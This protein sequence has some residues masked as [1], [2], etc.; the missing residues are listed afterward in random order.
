MGCAWPSAWPSGSVALCH[1]ADQ[2]HGD[3]DGKQQQQ[4]A[5]DLGKVYER[6]V[7]E[8]V[9]NPGAADHEQGEPGADT[10]SGSAGAGYAALPGRLQCAVGQEHGGDH[11]PEQEDVRIDQHAD[12]AGPESRVRMESLLDDLGAFALDCDRVRH[13]VLDAKK[14]DGQ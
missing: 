6:L 3:R 7:G 9:A 14:T 10:E 8:S 12:K 1:G 11:D 5:G 2:S 13:Q 4:D